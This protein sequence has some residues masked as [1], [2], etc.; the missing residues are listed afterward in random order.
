MT[1]THKQKKIIKLL[2]SLNEPLSH[3]KAGSLLNLSSFQMRQELTGLDKLFSCFGIELLN[4]PG[5]GLFISGSP[6]CQTNLSKA[7]AKF[8][9]IN[10]LDKEECY[11]LAIL[12]L[13]INDDYLKL[14]YLSYYLPYSNSSISN[15]IREF[16]KKTFF[17]SYGLE[18]ESKK[19][20]GIKIT[21]P[22]EKRIAYTASLICTRINTKE[23]HDFIRFNNEV[24][25][26]FSA[27]IIKNMDLEQSHLLFYLERLEQ[28]NELKDLYFR[29]LLQ[30][31]FFISLKLRF[32]KSSDQTD[33][34]I[35]FGDLTNKKK[36]LFQIKEAHKELAPQI[37][38][39]LVSWIENRNIFLLINQNLNSKL[40]L[41]I[42]ELLLWEEKNLFKTLSHEDLK[43]IEKT[44]NEKSEKILKSFSEYDS[45]KK[46]FQHH[47][48]Y[49]L[50]SIIH[51]QHAVLRSIC[52][53]IYS[54]YRDREREHLIRSSIDN[55]LDCNLCMDFPDISTE[56]RTRIQNQIVLT[57][58]GITLL[59]ATENDVLILPEP[60][61]KSNFIKIRD[62]VKNQLRQQLNR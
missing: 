23:L 50:H 20:R 27:E 47:L 52:L 16:R 9:I 55:I 61:S 6:N 13:L 10:C 34:P 14:D 7:L 12:H 36:S 18:F 49:L 62:F 35:D 1:L 3:Y 42:E 25:D 54:P 24:T 39:E 28:R 8:D 31:I 60:L 41:T 29:D 57:F 15:F 44:F 26:D 46:L 22:L 32:R 59:D 38:R 33:E 40:I 51:E 19:G 56:E 37:T 58:R 21:G 4:K 11:I 17:D 43:L 48:L 30:I 2:L 5:T 53:S 45:L